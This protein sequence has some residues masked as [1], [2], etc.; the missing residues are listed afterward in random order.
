MNARGTLPGIL[1]VAAS[2]TMLACDRTDATSS[3]PAAVNSPADSDR[4][5][6]YVQAR[7]HSDDQIRA[8]DID[9]SADG[10][11]VTL[12]GTV[13]S[14]EARQHA[15]TVARE[16]TG[17]QS[18][19]DRLTVMAAAA[20]TPSAS[21]PAPNPA[22]SPAVDRTRQPGWITTKIQAQYFT[23]PEISPWNIDVTTASNGVVTLSGR[24]ESAAD[25]DEAIRIARATDGVTDVND[26][27]TIG[28]TDAMPS[29][30]DGNGSDQPDPWITAK[31]QSKYFLD[32]EVKGRNINVDTRNGQVTLHGS[33]GSEAER[34]QAVSIARNTEGVRD[35]QD[36]LSIDATTSTPPSAQTG[37]ARGADAVDDAWVMVKIQSKFF[38]DRD[39]KG[40]TIDVASNGGTVTLQGTVR[41]AAEKEAAEQIARATDGVTSVDNRLQ[42]DTTR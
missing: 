35:V 33:V 23:D 36:R 6:T 19:D 16:V 10:G 29:A 30:A 14:E 40:R 38:L 17:V 41:S 42:V 12:T 8:H 39:I 15:L 28:E 7:F 20:T 25:R 22:A 26:R 9:V 21:D 27:L 1:A 4:V 11:R 18:V 34:R 37:L 31:I 32:A 3:G 24:V 13:P 2:L 5:E